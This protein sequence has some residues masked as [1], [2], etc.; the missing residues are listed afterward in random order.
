MLLLFHVAD[1]P[2]LEGLQS[3]VYWADGWPKAS[4]AVV[5]EAARAAAAGT[6][7]C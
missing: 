5:A 2:S 6:L 3:G 1:E 7:T 4:R